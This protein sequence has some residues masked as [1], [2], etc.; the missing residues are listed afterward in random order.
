M[1]PNDAI[2]PQ[3]QEGVVFK[4]PCEC[5]KVYIGEMGRCMYEQIKEHD[6]DIWLSQTQ[7]SAFS[8]H[9]NKTGH[10]PLWKEVKVTDRDPH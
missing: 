4:I 2:N 8:E 7:T 1:Q 9:A 3:K 5:G 6:R 10:Y